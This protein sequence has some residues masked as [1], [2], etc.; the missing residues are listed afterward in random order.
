MVPL[1][2]TWKVKNPINN[3]NIVPYIGKY[4]NWHEDYAGEKGKL[5]LRLLGAGL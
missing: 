2:W 5:D 4:V 1:S 3:Y